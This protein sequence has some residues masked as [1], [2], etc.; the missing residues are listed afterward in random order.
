M[1]V[2]QDATKVVLWCAGNDLLQRSAT[3]FDIFKRPYL[4]LYAQSPNLSMPGP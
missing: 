3:S 1:Q 2:V 4:W